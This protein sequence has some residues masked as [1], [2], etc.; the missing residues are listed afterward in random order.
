MKRELVD[1][2]QKSKNEAM[3]E[4]LFKRLKEILSL[5]T[6]DI[7]YDDTDERHKRNYAMLESC[8]DLLSF[9]SMKDSNVTTLSAY[10]QSKRDGMLK[11]EREYLDNDKHLEG[12]EAG[13][14]IFYE[15][16]C[17]EVEC[18]EHIYFPDKRRYVSAWSK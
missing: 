5:I 1:I 12:K 14:L 16:M 6:S 7:Y 2:H 18:I 3:K 9:V 10:I 13:H 15:M 4:H 8:I 17:D 11:R